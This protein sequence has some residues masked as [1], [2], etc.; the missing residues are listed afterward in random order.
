MSFDTLAITK[1]ELG[2]VGRYLRIHVDGAGADYHGHR[3]GQFE[4]Y[5]YPIGMNNYTFD[6]S[7]IMVNIV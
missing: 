7:I 1:V 4:F 5:G 2:V 6:T 3:S